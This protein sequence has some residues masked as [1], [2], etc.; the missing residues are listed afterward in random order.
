M[1]WREDNPDA[2]YHCLGGGQVANTE[3]REPW[4]AWEDLPPGSDLAVTMGLVRPEP[5]GECGG[6]GKTPVKSS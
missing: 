1:T 4:S 3:D 2:C 6:S 5:C